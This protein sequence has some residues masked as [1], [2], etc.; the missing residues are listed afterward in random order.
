MTNGQE[1]FIYIFLRFSYPSIIY[2]LI[3]VTNTAI[4]KLPKI[5]NKYNNPDSKLNLIKLEVIIA[6]AL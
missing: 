4:I 3:K 6:N 1:D 5:K 2:E